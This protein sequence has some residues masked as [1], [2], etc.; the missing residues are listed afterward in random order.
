MEYILFGAGVVALLAL[1]YVL[2]DKKWR[3]GKRIE[4]KTITDA[5]KL[6]VMQAAFL[7][8][9][10]QMVFIS[11][12]EGKVVFVNPRFVAVTGYPLEVGMKVPMEEIYLPGEIEVFFDKVLPAML[13]GETVYNEIT[14]QAKDGK[15][16][17]VR[18]CTF[19]LHLET[20]EPLFATVF[21]E[22]GKDRHLYNI[23][24]WQRVIVEHSRGFA[25][26]FDLE[27]RIVYCNHAMRALME[28]QDVRAREWLLAED[29]ARLRQEALPGLKKGQAW[30]GEITLRAGDGALIP[31]SADIFPI[32]NAE[33]EI[34]GFAIMMY[35]ARQQKKLADSLH[36]ATQEARAANHAKSRFLSQTSHEIRTPLN[37]IIGM[38]QIAQKSTAPEEVAGCLNQIDQYSKKLLSIINDVLDISKIE[39]GKLQLNMTTFNFEHMLS[40]TCFLVMDKVR[41]KNIDFKV[42][43]DDALH[44]SYHGDDVRI[45]QILTNFLSNAVKFTPENGI[46]R[47]SA[48]E[49]GSRD[50][51]AVLHLSVQDSGIGMTNEQAQRVFSPFEQA[52]GTIMRRYGG[53]GLGLP[54]S[55]NLAEM[56]GGIVWV[57]S[58]VGKGSVFTAEICLD[59]VAESQELELPHG[60]K[61]SVQSLKLL[62]L[63]TDKETVHPVQ[64]LSRRLH[65]QYDIVKTP[66]DAADYLIA[67]QAQG[68]PY[69]MFLYTVSLIPDLEEFYYGLSL[70]QGPYW[71]PVVD[72]V[73]LNARPIYIEVEAWRPIARPFFAS[74]VFDMLAE[75]IGADEEPTLVAEDMPLQG[76]TVL[77]AE[78]VEINRQI[79]AATM[80]GLGMELIFAENGQAAVDIFKAAPDRYSAILMDV[81]MPLMDGLEATRA[82]RRL[83]MPAAKQIPIIAMTANVFR[84]DVEECMGAGMNDH[85]AKPIEPKMAKETL[86]RY[87]LEYQRSLPMKRASSALSPERP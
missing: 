79:F 43:V 76:H 41:Q 14:I 69:D 47:V 20:Q 38:T 61:R 8:Q 74:H 10:E 83:E 57:K 82:I 80:S 4:E 25:I 85:L 19:S 34:V 24:D 64:R 51:K 58:E 7:E 81:Q 39:D 42:T 66:R 22:I 35:D 46:I 17:A 63:S 70:K 67:A 54:I 72:V 6:A 56:M 3:K 44:Y 15:R 33:K 52:D 36:R 26:C 27:G 65:F 77:L 18:S 21:D 45:S 48:Q 86:V 32:V 87:A 30:L 23:G 84:E 2:L 60:L 40:H 12:G 9:I 73:G 31:A 11:D 5:A 68:K 28:D 1:E 78:D 62:V 13:R 49:V 75:I 37:A 53:T 16:I 59:Y 29:E 50:E 71:V 55:K